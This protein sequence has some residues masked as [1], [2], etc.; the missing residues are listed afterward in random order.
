MAERNHAQIAD[1]VMN[2]GA[3]VAVNL[4]LHLLILMSSTSFVIDFA[5]H[6]LQQH[7]SLEEV[8]YR[9]RSNGRFAPYT[10]GRGKRKGKPEHEVVIKDVCLLPD[11]EWKNVPRCAVKE[12]L[13]RQNLYIDAWSMAKSW[14]E[15]M[16]R[17]EI[18][19]LFEDR[20]EG[21]NG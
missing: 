4:A 6:V 8:F 15:E 18:R 17:R 16:L 9:A 12:T 7:P 20:L 1:I 5:F 2:V 14:S 11:P 19:V 10:R 3:L 21:G 13:V